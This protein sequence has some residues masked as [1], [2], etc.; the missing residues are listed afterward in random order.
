LIPIQESKAQDIALNANQLYKIADSLY[1]ANEEDLARDTLFVL[2]PNFNQINNDTLESKILALFGHLQ[3]NIGND[4]VSI[5]QY[6]RSLSKKQIASYLDAIKAMGQYFYARENYTK[7]LSYFRKLLLFSKNVNN[8]IFEAESNLHLG[9]VFLTMKHTDK[10]KSYFNV[11]LRHA[12]KTNNS[13]M[14]I[15]IYNHLGHINKSESNIDTAIYY[16]KK[17]IE[18]AK[19][20]LSI[21]NQILANSNLS[22][23]MEEKGNYAESI[24]YLKRAIKLAAARDA[25]HLAQ[26]YY[27][28]AELYKTRNNTI[29][30]KKYYHLSNSAA[31]KN[32]H[33]Q[34]AIQS[35]KILGGIYL[36]EGNFRR[37]AKYLHKAMV[38][39]DSLMQVNSLK[40]LAKYEAQYSLMQKEQE[41]ALLDRDK[42]LNK[43]KL[44]N[45]QFKS[46]VYI[47]GL[48]ALIL[49]V[50][51]LLYHISSRIKRNKILSGQNEKINEQ[52]EELN[53]INQQLSESEQK[54]IQALSVK[55]KLFTIIGHDLKSPLMDIK[56]LIFI[57]KS[58]ALRFSEAEL[59]KH[60]SQIE[61]RLTSLL[62]LLNNLLNW[63]MAEKQSLKYTPEK[64]SIN[65]LFTKTL[66]LF[67]GQILS[68]GLIIKDQIP[69]NLNWTTDHN[70]LEFSIRNILS[71]AIK[72][73]ENN[74]AIN[75]EII[76]T[77]KQLNIIIEDHGIGM[78][79]EELSKVFIQTSDKVR[80]GT[81][82]E[83][84]TGLGMA[85][86]HEFA[87]QMNGKLQIES[88]PKIGT[89]VT[90]I[91]P[92]NGQK[93]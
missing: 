55:N 68:K 79:E 51:V 43:V 52:N 14:I 26:L 73:S 66:N 3:K 37:A 48:V 27:N 78:N 36:K 84:G 18:L 88:K 81:N 44:S 10:A 58:N 46:R 20:N 86:A 30:A 57:L 19:N 9:E 76:K 25:K 22:K 91:L 5:N 23:I 41:I 72:F 6:M 45:E 87:I 75:I 11:A 67:E 13:H 15:S 54:L 29:E 64:I 40:E 21:E 70:M 92:E 65:Q 8:T 61:N 32:Y 59:S 31:L 34:L 63:G 12:K 39:N 7:A 2:F 90:L 1:K 80:R 16:Y 33:T 71:N 89:K 49:I 42:K 47:I 74:S 77:N 50:L 35:G 17:T 24:T 28:L 38:L 53:Q 83:K 85:L 82:N 60:T 4:T 56:N 93:V 69:K 62:E